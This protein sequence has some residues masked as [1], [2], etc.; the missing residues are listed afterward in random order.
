MISQVPGRA[1][2]PGELGSEPPPSRLGK[3]ASPYPTATNLP[4]GRTNCPGEPL[5]S[6]PKRKKLPHEVPPWVTQGAR[7]FITINCKQ[8]TGSPLLQGTHATDLLDSA[9]YYEQ[10]GHW[11]LG[12]RVVMPD[13]LHFLATSNLGRGIQA[14]VKAWKRQ[15]ARH[16]GLAWQTGFFE[17]RLRNDAEFGEKFHYIL[18]NPV[19]KGLVRSPNDWPFVLERTALGRANRLGEPKSRLGKVATPHLK[20]ENDQE[21]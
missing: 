12:L 2:P 17:H 10:L 8:R 18:W 14:T 7:H 9:A 15:Q 13:H 20:T 16:W 4:S 19:R 11:Y 6:L 5:L 1:N 3:D 21:N